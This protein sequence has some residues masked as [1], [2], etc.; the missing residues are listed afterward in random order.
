[1]AT[2]KQPPIKVPKFS[3]EN[4]FYTTKERSEL[5]SK[6]K[7]K[8]TKP[9][10]FLRKVLYQLGVRYRVNV[11]DLPGRPDIAIKKH[12]LAIFVDGEFWHGHDWE[13]KK[14]QIKNNRGFWVPKIERNIQRD[15]EVNEQYRQMGWKVLRFWEQEIKKE[16]GR[17]IYQV[18][19]SID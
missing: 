16:P 9:E 3:E 5:M 12:K 18:L 6:I 1:M 17:C 15:E 10:V 2:Y 4:G 14:G 8:N 11:K 13:N 7:G 19:N